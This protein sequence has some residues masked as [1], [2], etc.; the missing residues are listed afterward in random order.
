L[1]AAAA[2]FD[3]VV[4]AGEP[5]AL[6]LYFNEDCWSD[7]EN[8]MFVW[9][10]ANV[11]E[12]MKQGLDYVLVSFYE[13]DCNDIQPDWLPVFERLAGI[14]PDA[15][16]GFGE[17]GTAVESRKVETIGRYYG[18][19]RLMPRFVGGFFWWYFRE[20]MVP[21]STEYWS[22]LN[23]YALQWDTLYP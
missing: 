6:T 13:D 23:E 12:R 22:V 15:S 21:S 1:R 9:T 2:A 16:P 14:F 11:P 17:V 19:P 5:T 8:E 7:P 20:D 3:I 4:E 18:M 10:E